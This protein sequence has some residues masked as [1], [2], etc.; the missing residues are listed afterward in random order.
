MTVTLS[1]RV[2]ARKYRPIDFSSLIGQDVLVRTLSNAIVSGRLA[3][4][5]VLTGVRGVGK[6]TVA[7]I[8][9]RALNCIGSSGNDDKPTTEPCGIC[10]NCKAIAEDRHIDIVEMD[11]ASCTSVN[12]IRELLEGVNYKP[13]SSRFK[14]Y[15]IDEVHMLSTAAFNALLKTLEEPPK[16]VKFILATTEIRKIPL[17]VLS[18]CQR[19]DLRRIDTNVLYEH[20]SYI[21]KKEGV[22]I[23]PVALM[24]ICRASDGS[25]RDGLSLLDKAIAHGIDHINEEQVRNMLGLSDRNRIFDLFDA[26]MKGEL[27]IALDQISEQYASGADPVVVL[28]DML[29]L[30]HWLTRL[31]LIPEMTE[32]IE[33]SETERIK[34]SLMAKT[35]SLATLTRTWQ[36]LLKGISETRISPFP[37]HAVEMVLVRLVY[38]ADLPSPV[39]VLEILKQQHPSSFS[40]SNNDKN[41]KIITEKTNRISDTNEVLL[42]T[43]SKD[44]PMIVPANFKEMVALFSNVPEIFDV[45]NLYVHLIHYEIG[46]IEFRVDDN[47]PTNLVSRMSNLLL[48]WTGIQWK[49]NL[50]KDS[51][52]ITLNEKNYEHEIENKSINAIN[53]PL[54]QAALK[55]FPDANVEIIRNLTSSSDTLELIESEF[56][57]VES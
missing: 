6:T 27:S 10:E 41:E 47:V 16:H 20:F 43:Q 17:T 35:L 55:V 1:Y 29:K 53:D 45:L 57:E 3:H 14:I 30:T 31:K 33:V 9:A 26:V 7:R 38:V 8:I 11:A 24:L 44:K 40:I 23:E 18:R 46:M 12:D 54:V 32:S 36:M 19:F 42:K 39:K 4:A 5:F 21:I 37:L 56:E 13:I 49:I 51:D 34:G 25:V 15:I 2:L 28:Y 22:T 50:F 52:L 48:E